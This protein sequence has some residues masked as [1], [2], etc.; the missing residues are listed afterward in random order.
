MF[1]VTDVPQSSKVEKMKNQE[2]IESFK[3]ILFT[4]AEHCFYTHL[5]CIKDLYNITYFLI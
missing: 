1:A 3:A 4:V 5:T 2:K